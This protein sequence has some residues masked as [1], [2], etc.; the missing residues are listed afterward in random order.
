MKIFHIISGYKIVLSL[1]ILY[2]LL[3]R[4]GHSFPLKFRSFGMKTFQEND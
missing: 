3:V 1:I 4:G 2:I